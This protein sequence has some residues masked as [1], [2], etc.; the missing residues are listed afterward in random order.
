MESLSCS[1]FICTFILSSCEHCHFLLSVCPPCGIV[2]RSVQGLG[3]APDAPHAVNV[4]F[5]TEGNGVGVLTEP[6][7][8]A[9]SLFTKESNH[10]AQVRTK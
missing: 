8:S 4:S 10:N 3:R 5:V 7:V 1:L 6:P 9:K 2:Y